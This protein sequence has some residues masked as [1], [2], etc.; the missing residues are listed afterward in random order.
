MKLHQWW[1]RVG[2]RALPKITKHILSLTCSGSSCKK[3][4]SM[5]SFV[6]NKSHNCLRVGKAEALVYIYTNSIFFKQRSGANSIHQCEN[7]IFAKNSD[8]G[9]D[10]QEIDSKG[11]DEGGDDGNI[12]ADGAQMWDSNEPQAQQ[13]L[14]NNVDGLDASSFDLD[15]FSDEHLVGGAYRG[16]HSLMPSD[17][18]VYSVNGSKDYDDVKVV[19]TK[20]MAMF[21][22]EMMTRLSIMMLVVMTSMVLST[23]KIIIFLKTPTTACTRQSRLQ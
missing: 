9:D 10:G 1:H 2:G 8:L 23:D 6:H 4:W 12:L 16:N 18:G 3:N 7:K 14:N 11:N 20:A 15:G 22:I 17:E 13:A 21:T 19:V 5:Y